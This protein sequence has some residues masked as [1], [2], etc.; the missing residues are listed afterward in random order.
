MATH[1]FG[2]EVKR[3]YNDFQWL[4]AV[5]VRDFPSLFVGRP[6]QIAPMAEKTQRSLE[7]DYL[8][9][10][11]GQLQ[12]FLDGLLES[13]EL[14]A[15]LPLLCFLKCANE[16]QWEKIKAELEKSQGRAAV[17]RR[18][19]NLRQNFSRKLFEGKVPLQLEDFE[20]V[21]P[22]YICKISPELKE[23]SQQLEELVKV[24]QPLYTK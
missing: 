22:E 24:S 3:R 16:E 20:T 23:Y 14:R 19:Q 18:Y 4:R 21:R 6:E 12:R 2:Y 10:R 15:S 9:K 8:H 7:P 1:P 11:A 5:L 13:E 17:G